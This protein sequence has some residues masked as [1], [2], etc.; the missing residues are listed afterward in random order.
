MEWLT[1]AGIAAG[2]YLIGSIPFGFLIGKAYGKDIRQFGSGNIGATNVVRV[3]GRWPG[4]CCFLLD[5]LKGYGPV[6]AVL[7]LIRNGIIA[8]PYGIAPL[9]AIAGTVAGHMF[10][11]FLRF[12]G[13]KGVATAAGAVFGIAPLALLTALAVWAA[14]FFW[15]RYVSLASIL[16]AAALPVVA[17]TYNGLGWECFSMPVLI[18]L[19]VLGAL[20]IYKHRSN[21]R[22]LFDGTENRFGGQPK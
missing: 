8:D 11:C 10:T 4:R 16:A 19:A 6:G 18:F 5:F 12:K 9:L 15:S 7:L 22:R 1:Y 20:A 14:A 17:V 21:I 3:I 2:A 13:G